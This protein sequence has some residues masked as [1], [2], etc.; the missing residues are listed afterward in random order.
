MFLQVMY[1]RNLWDNAYISNSLVQK[2]HYLPALLRF[3]PLYLIS[4]FLIIKD[5]LYVGIDLGESD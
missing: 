2:S 4:Q 5:D 1:G 3:I